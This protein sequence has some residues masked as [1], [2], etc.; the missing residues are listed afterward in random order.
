MLALLDG[1]PQFKVTVLAASEPRP[2][3]ATPKRSIGTWTRPCPIGPG[4]GGP[5][6]RAAARLRLRPVRSRQR[7]PA[8]SRPPFAAAGYPRHFPTPKITDG[9]RRA[10]V[11]PRSTATTGRHRKQ[12]RERGWKRGLIVTNP[13]CFDGRPGLRPEAASGRFRREKSHR[14][15]HAGHFRGRLPGVPSLTSWT[16][17]FLTSAA[18]RR[19][20]SPSR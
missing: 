14:H 12:R 19:R 7:V 6:S 18:K 10:A 3:R 8:R 2:A 16:T 4:H 15:H 13:N 1:H 11:V 20:C 17:S 5:E 9:G